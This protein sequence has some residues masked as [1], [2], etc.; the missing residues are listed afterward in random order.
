MLTTTLA[1]EI[2]PTPVMMIP[3]GRSIAVSPRKPPPNERM[4]EV[5]IMSDNEWLGKNQCDARNKRDEMVNLC[6]ALFFF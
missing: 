3:K 5:M 4:T 6:Q 2:T 1:R